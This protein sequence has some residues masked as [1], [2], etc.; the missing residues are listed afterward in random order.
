PEIAEGAG[1]VVAAWLPGEEAGHAVAGV[2]FGHVNPSGHTT[3]TWSRGAGQQPLYYNDKRLGR[4]GYARSTTRPVFPFGHGLSYTTF[5]YTDLHLSAHTID[6]AGVVDI[7]CTIRNTGDPAGD[8]VVQLYV[9][10]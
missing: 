1:A 4:T 8:E 9:H 5:E 6:T 2:L 3:V 7:A 10:D